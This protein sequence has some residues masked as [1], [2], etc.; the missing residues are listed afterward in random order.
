MNTP[1]GTLMSPERC[2][3]IAG[4][5]DPILRNLQITQS[6]HDLSGAMH[7][8]L[9]GRDAN[10]CTFATWASKQAGAFIRNDEVPRGAQKLLGI[11]AGGASLP[12]ASEA[13]GAAS[14][15]S[16][17]RGWLLGFVVETVED[18]S[19]HI[20]DGNRKVYA[21]L[22]PIFARFL[23]TFG[24]GPG[25]ESGTIERF[26]ATLRPGNTADGGQERLRRAFRAYHAARRV[27][28]AKQRAEVILLANL[29]VGQHEQIRLQSAIAESMD[30]PFD[31]AVAEA[32]RGAAALRLRAVIRRLARGVIGQ[33]MSRAMREAEE[34]WIRAETE[35][36][37]TLAL[38]DGTLHLGD[39]LPPLPDGRAVPA[40]LE[41][42][43][44]ADLM[45]LISKIRAAR[46]PTRGSGAT[47]W[48]DL[49][50]RMGFIC[51][52]F[53]SRQQDE[54][55]LEQPFAPEQAALIRSGRV[56]EGRL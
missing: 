15:T 49:D 9:G 16:A 56:P 45:A 7:R 31:V 47:D 17:H 26:C 12:G 13:S 43:R 14:A 40:D 35:F 21:E 20:A 44:N 46:G 50:D 18:V 30:A 2:R 36:M 48:A 6:Y 51:A 52:L 34:V 25:D 23:Q 33:V 4:L 53:R 42:I 29:L 28:D 22:G 54:R 38:P 10:W 27:E 1:P 37:M 55:L 32:E 8:W 39:D 11:E 24:G 41:H 3:E 19:R 5:A